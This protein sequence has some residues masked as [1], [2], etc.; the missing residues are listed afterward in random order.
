MFVEE[1]KIHIEVDGKQ[2]KG[3]K[4]ALTDLK[5]SY[6]SFCEGYITLHVPNSLIEA[7]LEETAD[8]LTEIIIENKPRSKRLWG[9]YR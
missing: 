9:E 7:N 8:W 4:Q 5:R 3:P 6:Y 1:A 2:H